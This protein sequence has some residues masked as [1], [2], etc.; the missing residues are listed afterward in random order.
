MTQHEA[1]ARRLVHEL[2][3]RL[4]PA[5]VTALGL[6]LNE[7]W[8]AKNAWPEW[9]KD[10]VHAAAVVSEEAGELVR[11]VNN[12]HYKGSPFQIAR[13]EAMQTGAMAIRF[14]AHAPVEAP[15]GELI[16]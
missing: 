11:A 16:Q 8:T 15:N 12:H 7:L 5:E 13:D 2:L 3:E 14:I 9:P 4:T 1:L 10:Q 6:I